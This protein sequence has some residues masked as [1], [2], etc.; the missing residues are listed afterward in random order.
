[1]PWD[2]TN[3]LTRRA[4]AFGLLAALLPA[5]PAAAEAAIAPP[6]CSELE[7]WLGG[8]DPDDRWQPLENNRGWVPRAFAAPAFEETFGRPA[9]TWQ[10]DDAVAVANRIYDCGQEAGRDGRRD[11][12]TLLYG[13]RGYFQGNLRGLLLAQAKAE[14]RAAREAERQAKREAQAAERERE[15]AERRKARAAEARAR[16]EAQ[17]RETAA[18]LE[19]AL[20]AFLGEADSPD[21]LRRLTMLRAVDFQNPESYGQAYGRVGRS[22]RQILSIL[23]N[24]GSD[25]SDPRVAPRLE[26]RERALRD[27]ITEHY[28]R[29]IAGLNDSGGSL[30]QLDHMEAEI[31]REMAPLLGAEAARELMAAV[32]AKRAAIR[33]E[34][35]ARAYRLIDSAETDRSDAEQ[36]IAQIGKI[37]AEARGLG[38]ARADLEALRDHA[39]KRQAALAGKILAARATELNDYPESLYGLQRLAGD[40][41]GT[42]R[43][44]AARAAE[45]ARRAYLDAARARLTEI[46]AASLPEFEAQLAALP[47]SAAGLKQS[48]ATVV[49]TAGFEQVGEAVRADYLAALE[50]R[51]AEISAALEAKMAARRRAAVQAGGD[52]ELV[53]RTF[54]DE[55]HFTR[56]EFRDEKLAIINIMGI[57]AAGDYQVS[58]DDVI[59]RGPQGS[60]VFTRRGSG[61]DVRLTGN[62]MTLEPAD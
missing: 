3:R 41:A 14:Q 8:I 56:I 47:E 20:D 44:P 50:A 26:A 11:A 46:A 55:K 62:G 9:M 60:L 5:A 35:L 7:A 36:A 13:A 48:E 4:T 16:A 30:R 17:Q 21:F 39:R 32:A 38:F 42:R 12:R 19:A 27:S 1:M 23:R 2:K 15:E 29:S 22:G 53:G 37:M 61:A 31:G 43:G 59:V 58:A 18:E 54:V 33:K 49:G 6:D 40:I 45:S 57:R 10:P 28:Q 25:M 52:P 24:Q 34:I 51:R